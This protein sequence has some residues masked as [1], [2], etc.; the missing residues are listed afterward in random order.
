M[1]FSKN[2]HWMFSMR[3]QIDEKITRQED[4]YGIHLVEYHFPNGMAM[5]LKTQFVKD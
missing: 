2:A 1:E 5:S 4:N 3:M